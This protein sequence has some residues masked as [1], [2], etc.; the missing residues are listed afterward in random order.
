MIEAKRRKEN[1]WKGS[2]ED[3]ERSKEDITRRSD[4]KKKKTKEKYTET[5]EPQEDKHITDRRQNDTRG[6][7]FSRKGRGRK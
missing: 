7:E 5:E 1:R 3:K 4:N 6:G 2:R